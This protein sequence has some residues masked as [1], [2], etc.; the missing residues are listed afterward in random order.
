[1]DKNTEFHLNGLQGKDYAKALFL[2]SI[3]KRL[4]WVFYLNIKVRRNWFS[5][6]WST[7]GAN[8][9]EIQIWIFQINIGMPWL[10]LPLKSNIR[11]YGTLQ[12]VKKINDGMLKKKWSWRIGTYPNVL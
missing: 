10:E 7:R 8:F 2:Y 6:W 3:I 9:K 11:D 1:M 5:Y 12:G 4:P